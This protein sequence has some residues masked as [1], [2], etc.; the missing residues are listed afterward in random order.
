M[1]EREKITVPA[2]RATLHNLKQISPR[3]PTARPIRCRAEG[4]CCLHV[5]KGGAS[6]CRLCIRRS[7]DGIENQSRRT[8]AIAASRGDRDCAHRPPRYD[9]ACGIRSIKRCAMVA[10]APRIVACCRPGA[11]A[12]T[13]SRKSCTSRPRAHFRCFLAT[14]PLR[15]SACRRQ[16]VFGTRSGTSRERIATHPGY[17]PTFHHEKLLTFS[18]RP[19]HRPLLT[20]SAR[21]SVQTPRMNL[22]NCRALE[23]ED[24]VDLAEYSPQKQ[25]LHG[26]RGPA[27]AMERHWHEWKVSPVSIGGKTF[28]LA[29]STARARSSHLDDADGNWRTSI[30]GCIGTARRSLRSRCP[31]RFSRR[32]ALPQLTCWRSAWNPG[33][34]QCL[35]IPCR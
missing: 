35:G 18:P 29:K 9:G 22:G 11:R 1:L 21:G 33:S 30:L 20:L 27:A 25:G 26:D 24:A 19:S 4:G 14:R 6:R 17:P 12:T 28:T 5:A 23:C 31:G 10:R 7:V 8:D 16:A 13:R 15:T 3:T 2:R 34:G 32:L